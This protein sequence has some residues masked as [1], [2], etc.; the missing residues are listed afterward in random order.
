MDR[1]GRAGHQS[2][3]EKKPARAHLRP[4]QRIAQDRIQRDRQLGL[5][6]DAHVQVVAQVLP[7]PG[8][9]CT[10]STPARASALRADRCRRARGAAA[11]ESRPA[12][13]HFAPHRTVRSSAALAVQSA[14]RAFVPR[15]DALRQRT[16]S[17]PSDRR[18]IAGHQI[19]I[20]GV[21][22]PTAAGVVLQIADAL[23]ARSVVIV[24]HGNARLLRNAA[25]KPCGQRDRDPCSA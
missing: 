6:R 3:S 16:R 2:A 11:T 18:F 14:R 1:R 12:R 25:M 20:G 8:N 7:T 23:E 19:V 24:G 15:H 22:A 5:E 21:T 9:S 4:L 13:E 17:R 10:T